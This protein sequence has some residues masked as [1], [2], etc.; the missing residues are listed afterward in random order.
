MFF[1]VFEYPLLM[2]PTE[3]IELPDCC[4]EWRF[5]A[6]LEENTFT[7]TEGVEEFLTVGLGLTLIVEVDDEFV[8]AEHI[9]GIVFLGVIG[10][11]DVDQT[12]AI[13]S[14]SLHNFNKTGKI[15][16]AAVEF[17]KTGD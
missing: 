4:N 16:D 14:I 9:G 5:A 12:Q 17:L 13:G 2:S 7:T 1:N 6:G 8:P 3:E 11:E 15:L 10:Y